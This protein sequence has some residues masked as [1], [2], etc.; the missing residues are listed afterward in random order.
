MP[1]SGH[2]FHNE[3]G[4]EG[5]M[6]IKKML[7]FSWLLLA[8]T[9]SMVAFAL[10]NVMT[11]DAAIERTQETRRVSLALAAELQES[12]RGLTEAVRMYAATGDNDAFEA[13]WD[14]VKVRSGEKARPQD[15]TV[16]P[17]RKI[18]L[19]ALMEQAG[20][21]G[22]ELGHLSQAAALSNALIELEEQ[23]MN[24]VQGKFRDSAGQY[25][26][27]KDPDT[28]LATRLVFSPGYRDSVRK[29]MEP[30]GNFQREMNSR[31]NDAVRERQNAYDNA[32]LMLVG[33]IAILLAAFCATLLMV[34]RVIVRP[35]LQ[36]NDF[37]M[38]VAG[39]DL[40]SELRYSSGTEIG[41]LAD[42]L[43][44]MVGALRA[45]IAQSEEATGKAREQ[46]EL[47]AGALREAE[48]ARLAA[49]SARSQGMRQAG[50][51]LLVVAELAQ[52]TIADLSGH[53]ARARQ[54]A[55][56]QQQRLMES[57]QAMEQLNIAVTEVAGNASVTT[58]SAE[59]ARKNAQEGYSVVNGVIEAIVKV[60][61]KTASLRQSLNLLGKEAEGIGR[62]MGVIS[63]IADQ[64][65]LLALNAAIEAARAGDAGRGFAV[66]ADEVRKLAEKT[67][68]ATGE[69]GSAVRAI[70]TGTAEN[71]RGMEDASNAVR[72]S[73]DLAKSAGASLQ[74]IVDIA[75]GTAEKIQSI[76]VAAEQQSSTCEHMSGTTESINMVATDTLAVMREADLSVAD[77]NSVMKKVL[78]LTDELRGA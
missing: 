57:S 43:R 1:F 51:Q 58:E 59:A 39:G 8:V 19:T 20:F 35:A 21:T 77:I 15:R 9:V 28:A 50:E 27:K 75:R 60:D 3:R 64:T 22:R 24:A 10:Y 40:D 72:E 74:L 61:A 2:V 49:E 30:I 44:S 14:I 25:S 16:A 7:L 31:L 73:T 48:S 46:S 71:I 78:E 34:A 4:S 45:R 62:V 26:I 67:M 17:G 42:S 68:Q 70:Q 54:G 76:A 13:Y 36:C 38:K 33:A 47:A 66:V 56:V 5:I 53:I 41:S 52:K 32:M 11:N 6:T 18:A 29:I 63:D 55:E 23:A 12:S 65:N 69:V 37:A